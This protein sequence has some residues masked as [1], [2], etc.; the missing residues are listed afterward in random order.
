MLVSF[1]EGRIEHRHCSKRVGGEAYAGTDF[2]KRV[3]GFI[4]VDWDLEVMKSDSEADSAN[5]TAR[6]GDGEAF[7]G[8]RSVGR[9]RHGGSVLRRTQQT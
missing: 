1:Q 5:T 4:N 7:W 8:G 2:G 9:G 6:N 3:G